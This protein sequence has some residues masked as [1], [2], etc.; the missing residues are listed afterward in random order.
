[1]KILRGDAA[2]AHI[3]EKMKA[4]GFYDGTVDSAWGGLSE[5][6][7]D[8]IIANA[9]AAIDKDSPILAPSEDGPL[10]WGRRVSPQFRASVRWIGTELGLDPNDLMDCMAWESD[11]TFS[12]SIVNK[13]G[14]GATGLIQ[15]M[16]STALPYFWTTAQIEAMTPAQRQAN[17]RAATARLA[18]LTAVEQLNYVFRY[19]R[20]YK[21]RLKNLGD[22]YMA[23]LW[24]GGVGQADSFVL[25]EKGQRP[26]TY[27]QNAG[28]DLNKD[29]AITRAE[30]LVKIREKA[31]KGR[32]AGNFWPGL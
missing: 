12:P 17:G 27:R 24:P 28:L 11:E 14:S 21:G 31:A 7:L 2:V 10:S 29:G 5:T 9:R 8:L 19:F 18:K 13:A 30:C 20:P 3:Q 23:I 22:V 1:M 15:F 16:P 4:A 32:Q 26:T 6:A 25:W